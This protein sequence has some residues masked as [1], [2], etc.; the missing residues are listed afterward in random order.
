MENFKAFV[1]KYR[2][3]IGGAAA[4]VVLA[5]LLLLLG[6]WKTLLLLILGV[7]GFAVGYYFEEPERAKELISRLLPRRKG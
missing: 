1:L 5:A 6:F 7:A 2:F 4:G 3:R